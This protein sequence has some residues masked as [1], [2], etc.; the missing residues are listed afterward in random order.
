MPL[1][2][3]EFQ[4]LGCFLANIFR[5]VGGQPQQFTMSRHVL[6]KAYAIFL[7]GMLLLGT[8]S[9]LLAFDLENLS[10]FANHFCWRRNTYLPDGNVRFAPVDKR[11][12]DTRK[13]GFG[14]YQLREGGYPQSV[15]RLG[16]GERL[17]FVSMLDP[18]H[19]EQ[20]PRH[21]WHLISV[22]RTGKAWDGLLINKERAL[23]GKAISQQDYDFL[24]EKSSL[25]WLDEDGRDR[26]DLVYNWAPPPEWEQVRERWK[27]IFGSLVME[28]IIDP[29][30]SYDHQFYYVPMPERADLVTPQS[31][32]HPSVRKV[33]EPG[34]A[35]GF[36]FDDEGECIGFATIE[37]R[38]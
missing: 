11:P 27:A 14:A 25:I 13:L 9:P 33:Y 26:K 29:N 5:R 6:R 34:T 12:A 20:L 21:L 37:I 38:P 18:P 23:R 32:L 3:Y 17:T 22:P 19:D 16:G 2:S 35:F 30:E 8:C 24:T 1:G 10:A 4:N 7:F 31:W 28:E 36:V 15:F